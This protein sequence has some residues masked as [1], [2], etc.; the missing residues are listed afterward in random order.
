MKH[1]RIW[2]VFYGCLLALTS[3]AYSYLSR[4]LNAKWLLDSAEVV[5]HARILS[6]GPHSVEP[7]FSFQPPLTTEGQIA[8]VRVLN[9][10]KG[11]ADESISVVFRLSTDMAQYTQLEEGQEYILFLRSQRGAYTFV[12][13]HNGALEIPPHQPLQYKSREPD[14]RIIEE[15][16][17]GTMKDA[18][19]IRLVCAEQLAT[20]PNEQAA[21]RLSDLTLEKDMPVQGVAYAGLIRLDH[22]PSAES[23]SRFFARS[24]DTKSLDRFRTTAY[25]NGDLKN[26]VLIELEGRFNVIGRDYDPNARGSAEKWKDFDLIGFLKSAP[27]QNRDTSSGRG[28]GIIA[29]IIGEQIDEH[30]VPAV[31]SKNYRTGSKAIVLELLDS[32]NTEIRFAA[33]VAVDR[34]IREPHRFPFPGWGRNAKGQRERINAYVDACHSWLATHK[35]WAKETE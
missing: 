15:L 17:L 20:F 12:D 34:M 2:L 23:L 14:S 26:R 18:G 27:W 3:A 24:D 13:G 1:V 30:G 29:E 32:E 35:L 5:C 22:P 4:P 6:I 28:N 33:A 8:W 7:D 11:T 9:I 31:I 21:S 10:I 25:S 19:R 16:T